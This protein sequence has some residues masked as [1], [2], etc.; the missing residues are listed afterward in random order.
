MWSIK[1]V[2]VTG[3]HLPQPKRICFH[4]YPRSEKQ[5]FQGRFVTWPPKCATNVLHTPYW[6]NKRFIVLFF[7][8]HH[9]L[10]SYISNTLRALITFVI[11]VKVSPFDLLV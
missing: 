5:I 3:K 6:A 10:S 2:V 7:L 1:T 8:I 4:F 9:T 11:I